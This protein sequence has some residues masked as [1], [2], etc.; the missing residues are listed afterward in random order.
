M[1]I[2]KKTLRKLIRQVI[3]EQAQ[4]G[5][6]K[7]LRTSNNKE[8][9]TMEEIKFLLGVY[10]NMIKFADD[11]DAIFKVVSAIGKDQGKKGMP[12]KEK[13][14]EIEKDLKVYIS[15]YE[16]EKVFTDAISLLIEIINTNNLDLLKK[17]ET[18]IDAK[19][20]NLVYEVVDMVNYLFNLGTLTGYELSI[21][22]YIA[23]G[24]KAAKEGYTSSAY[25]GNESNRL[26]NN[27]DF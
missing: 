5:M 2:N 18:H 13:L 24:E 17:L 10:T 8:L 12:N 7:R 23:L 20:N 14:N 9:T 6:E 15:I 27:T 3:L 19:F 26:S 16:T 4:V 11:V 22:E 21:E 25:P 1:K